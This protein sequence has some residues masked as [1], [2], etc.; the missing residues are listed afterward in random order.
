MKRA[1]K[2]RCSGPSR[3]QDLLE[4]TSLIGTVLSSDNPI[5]PWAGVL[6]ALFLPCT[7]TWY[8]CMYILVLV[9]LFHELSYWRFYWN[10]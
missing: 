9:F 7:C 5:M 4:S 2:D 1:Y 6:R 8:I 10:S 3:K